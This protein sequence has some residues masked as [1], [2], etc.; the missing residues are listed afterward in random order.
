M[1]ANIASSYTS[2][3]AGEH[4]K[5][6]AAD[7][8]VMRRLL[9]AEP[10]R[11]WMSVP[12]S[13]YVLGESADVLM[14]KM[15]QL[16][17]RGYEVGIENVGEDVVEES[18]VL[19]VAAEYERLISLLPRGGLT[20]RTELNFDLSNVGLLIS[21]SLALDVASGIAAAA[22]RRGLCVTIS[23]ERRPLVD[24][25]LSVFRQLAA[26]AP[27]V[28]ITLQAYLKRTD[29]DLDTLI[30]T[31]CKV[32]LVKGVYADPS[33]DV[34]PR[35]PQLDA[36]YLALAQRLAEAGVPRSFATH[37]P[38]VIARLEAAGLLGAGAEIEMLHGVQADQL[39]QL[40]RRG[41]ACRIYGVYGTR[42]NLHFLHRL[43]ESPQNVLQALADAQDAS[44]IQFGA[45]Y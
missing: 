13:R 19:R 42:W 24:K 27:N 39:G 1:N 7:Q 9:E 34:L 38:A 33:D 28:G 40:R 32:R 6:L 16:A 25:I 8:N 10:V 2:L 41:I 20:P 18:E 30:E 35:S 29:A 26:R 3:L 11:R 17:A 5:H 45:G 37:D 4:L 21:E 15:G 23:M 44:R 14:E 31:G 22:H 36:R 12:A 43:A